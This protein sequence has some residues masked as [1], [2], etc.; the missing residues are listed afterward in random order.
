MIREVMILQQMILI[1]VVSSV[2]GCSFKNNTIND[3]E[4]IIVKYYKQSFAYND[5]WYKYKPKYHYYDEA[6]SDFNLSNDLICTG[7]DTTVSK[8]FFKNKKAYKANIPFKSLGYCTRFEGA[9]K[10]YPS[11]IREYDSEGKIIKIILVGS[12]SKYLYKYTNNEKICTTFYK[13]SNR[14]ET[15]KYIYDNNHKILKIEKY[16]NTKQ[17][18][19]FKFDKKDKNKLLEYDM[20]NKLTGE[21]LS[22]YEDPSN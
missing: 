14:T 2:V 4:E 6:S 8:V 3:N 16:K 1:I 9:D 13:D 21:S 5:E 12:N 19:V 18:S 11:L 10:I 22:L 20:N 15:Y 17:S 7:V